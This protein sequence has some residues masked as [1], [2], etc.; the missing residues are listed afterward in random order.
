MYVSIP[1][2][3]GGIAFSNRDHPLADMPRP[4]M[5]KPHIPT[6]P[7]AEPIPPAVQDE[8]KD[9]PKEPS[10]P[11]N[12]CHDCPKKDQN[13]LSCLFSALRNRGKAGLDTEDLLLIG[14]IVLLLGKEGNED[15]VLSLAMLLLV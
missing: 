7:P 15:I 1:K 5:P 13:P 12:P 2:N 4:D 6:P 11:I 8:K 9:C 3:Y 10:E 14:L